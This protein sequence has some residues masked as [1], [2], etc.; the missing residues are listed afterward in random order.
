MGSD[1]ASTFE[2]DCVRLSYERDG[3]GE[4]LLFLVG[5]GSTVDSMRLLIE[6]FSPHFDVAAHDPRGMGRSDVPPGPWTMADMAADAAALADHLGWDRFRLFGVSFGGM[7]GQELAVTWPERVERLVLACTS[8]GG[9]GGSSYPLHELDDLPAA[10]A[11][12]VAARLLDTRFTPAWLAEHPDDAA[13]VQV[14]AANRKAPV[15]EEHRRG[16][17]EQMR[18][19]A[20]HDV[21]DRLDRIS[22]PTL[23]ACGRYDGIAPA[24]NGER[25]ASRIAGSELRRYEGGHAFFVQDPAAMPD[26]VAFLQS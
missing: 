24:E 17:I 4:P 18:A 14:L 10:E 16:A 5:S 23:V 6:A 8:A 13:L 3:E 21:W 15:D 19:R 22:A 2:R 1:H 26:I 25:I 9:E 7:V 20:T 11:D 12:E